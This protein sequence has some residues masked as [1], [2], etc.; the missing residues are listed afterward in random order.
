MSHT[1]NKPLMAKAPH[2]IR[3]T[4]S[5]STS[6]GVL[7]SG[8]GLFCGGRV[9]QRENGDQGGKSPPNQ[10]YCQEE[11]DRDNANANQRNS[12]REDTNTGGDLQ[13]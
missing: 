12:G 7:P 9:L 6:F 1:T 13:K 10:G 4:T 11:R 5:R 8:S 2:Q 3:G